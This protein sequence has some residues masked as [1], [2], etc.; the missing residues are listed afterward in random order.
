MATAPM[1][2]RPDLGANG[3]ISEMQ[4]HNVPAPHSWP[5]SQEDLTGKRQQSGRVKQSRWSRMC[6]A[7]ADTWTLEIIL[8][9]FSLGCLAAIVGVLLEHSGKP[10]PTLP[11]NLTLNALISVIGVGAKASTLA[12]VASSLGQAKWCHFS[13]RAR[14]LR[15]AQAFDDASSGPLGSI[16]LLFGR[17]AL[18]LPAIG[19]VIIIAALP[20]DPFIQ[21]L[22]TFPE[23]LSTEAVTDRATAFLGADSGV[24]TQ[25]IATAIYGNINDFGRR[26]GCQSGNCTWEPFRSLGWCSKCEDMTS[27]VDV[28]DC[29]FAF[30]AADLDPNDAPYNGSCSISFGKGASQRL[31]WSA[32]RTD[33]WRL[34][35]DTEAIW[36]VAQNSDYDGPS[37]N[38]TILDVPWPQLVLGHVRMQFVDPES[39]EKG[40]RLANATQCALSYC[41]TNDSVT[42]TGGVH[43]TKRSDINFGHPYMHPETNRPCW[44]ADQET[45]DN[46]PP[47]TNTTIFVH[48]RSLLQGTASTYS[49]NPDNFTFCFDDPASRSTTLGT[50]APEIAPSITGTRLTVGRFG[51][52]SLDS[53]VRVAP[54]DTSLG[55]GFMHVV[56]FDS[57]LEPV[58]ERFAAAYTDMALRHMPN[59]TSEVEGRM[60][61]AERRVSVRWEWAALPLLLW[62]GSVVFLVVVAVVTRR[63]GVPL[64]KG[65]TL[66]YLYHGLE[67]DREEWNEG[68]LVRVSEMGAAAERTAVML[69][70]SRAKGR[71]VLGG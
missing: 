28:S 53:D 5:G 50:W 20:W 35:V 6:M 40:I 52:A 23:A 15:E 12:V 45:I 46:P 36:T 2:S 34:E 44:T 41:V 22:I 70:V 62:L 64:W 66:A 51:S 16:W 32:N 17:T 61:S 25:A 26:P 65:S 29:S 3:S 30:D 7:T 19:A 18:S 13:R 63:S 67:E 4:Y 68:G 31:E 21:Q 24:R 10:A 58:A 55:E 56:S 47:Y 59:T 11:F 60:F 49:T 8:V 42:V 27:S 38:A 57:G 54:G 37:D 43:S 69:G 39:P 14:P 9:L 1:D 33:S 48:S 71:L